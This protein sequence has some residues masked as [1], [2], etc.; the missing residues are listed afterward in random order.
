MFRL[1]IRN[2]LFSNS[3]VRPWN[4]LPS[5]VVESPSLQAIKSRGDVAMRD[6]VGG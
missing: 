2:N 4:G 6:V 5:E 3:V 1:R